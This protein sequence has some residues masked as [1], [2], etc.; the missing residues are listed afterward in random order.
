MCVSD[1]FLFRTEMSSESE[2]E[3]VA[4]LREAIDQDFIKKSLLSK[5]NRE[6][7]VYGIKMYN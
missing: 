2:E 4:L 7:Y 1:L 5:Q 3:N 6:Y